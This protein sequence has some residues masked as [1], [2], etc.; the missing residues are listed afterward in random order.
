MHVL[1]GR[2]QDAVLACNRAPEGIPNIRGWEAIALHR[3]GREEEAARSAARFLELTHA[4]WC[5]TRPV[6]DQDICA[7]FEDAFP[8]RDASVRSIVNTTLRELVESNAAA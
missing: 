5:G 6:T 7:W 2:D 8:I 4:N 1:A 3:L